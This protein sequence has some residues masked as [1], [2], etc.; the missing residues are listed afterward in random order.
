[1]LNNNKLIGSIFRKRLILLVRYELFPRKFKQTLFLGGNEQKMAKAFLLVLL[2]IS[3]SLV[4]IQQANEPNAN[5]MNIF[6][7]ANL[8]KYLWGGI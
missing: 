7:W 5:Q 6:N 8:T 2:I 1:M 4:H 3:F